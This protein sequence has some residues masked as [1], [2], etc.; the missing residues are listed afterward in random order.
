MIISKQVIQIENIQITNLMV[1]MNIQ[2]STKTPYTYSSDVRGKLEVKRI[3][4]LL[5]LINKM[6]ARYHLLVP[7]CILFISNITFYAVT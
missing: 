1:Y 7:T 6:M 3:T 2:D 5:Y 4:G